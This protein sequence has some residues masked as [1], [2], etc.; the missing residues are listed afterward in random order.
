[1]LV[2]GTEYHLQRILVLSAA[3]QPGNTLSQGTKL[4]VTE[5]CSETWPAQKCKNVE[6]NHA[7]FSKLETFEK[8]TSAWGGGGIAT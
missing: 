8:A 4:S 7:D 5:L 6:K 2:T 3:G 1:M